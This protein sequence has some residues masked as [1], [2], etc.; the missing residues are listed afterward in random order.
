MPLKEPVK[1]TCPECGKTDLLICT[2]CG[3]CAKC[4]DHTHCN[5]LTEREKAANSLALQTALFQSRKKGF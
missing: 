4:Y 3:F 2:N 5:D 1:G